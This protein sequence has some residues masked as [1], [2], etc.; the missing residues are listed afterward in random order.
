MLHS[1]LYVSHSPSRF[2]QPER[3]NTMQREHEEWGRAVKKKK[4]EKCSGCKSFEGFQVFA[5]VFWELESKKILNWKGT[6]RIIE[7]RSLL[8]TELPKPKPQD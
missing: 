1:F 8:L 2:H 4:K 6:I 3:E 7:S 5:E